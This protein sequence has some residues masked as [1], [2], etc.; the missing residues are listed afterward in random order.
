M[1]RIKE[2]ILKFGINQINLNRDEKES[3]A[4]VDSFQLI[5]SIIKNS[6]QVTG[7]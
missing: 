1:R 6:S 2:D 5:V 7:I 4:N 3:Y